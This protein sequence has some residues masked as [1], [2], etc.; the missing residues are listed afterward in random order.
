VKKRAQKRTFGVLPLV[1]IR[2]RGQY[3]LTEE[4]IETPSKRDGQQENKGL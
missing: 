4:T 3:D 1:K 2:E